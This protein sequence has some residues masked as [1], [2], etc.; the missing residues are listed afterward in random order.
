MKTALLRTLSYTAGRIAALAETVSQALED[1]GADQ[2]HFS[3]G[4]TFQ[5]KLDAGKLTGA[6][7]AKGATGATGPQG[8]TGANATI[9]G[10][11]ALTINGGSDISTSQSGSTL[12]LALKTNG[13]V[14][15]TY[16]M[17]GDAIASAKWASNNGGLNGTTATT[18]WTAKADCTLV[19]TYTV[20]S[21]SV[22]YDYLNIQAAGQQLLANTGG[23]E[24]TGTL[25]ATLTAGQ[26][27]VFTYR[28]D[29]S[30]HKNDDRAE[31]SSVKHTASGASSATTVTSKNLETF[32]TVTHGQ[33][34]FLPLVELSVFAKDGPVGFTA[35]YFTLDAKG[36]VTKAGA[37]Y[38]TRAAEKAVSVT[39]PTSGWNSDSTATY[40]KYY[41][42]SVSGVTAK[43]RA[44]VD[45]SP[46]SLKTAITCGMCPACETLADKIRIRAVSVPT[47]SLTANY[48]VEKGA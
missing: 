38:V 46:A 4:E 26:S 12:S 39:I 48:W 34:G 42:I 45:L 18:T 35:P 3:D 40:P 29:G 41:D 5:Q 30:A 32:F 31:I 17:N 24:R 6:T 9:N 8:P 37:V 22:S 23:D 16:G 11:N 7:G 13:V 36:R 28:K 1:I 43:D 2:V 27:I 21:E 47:A 25:T 33:Y 19:F 14:A 44:K 20:S 10:V 15:G